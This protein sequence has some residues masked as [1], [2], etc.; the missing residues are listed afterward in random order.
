MV[1]YPYPH[2]I[3]Q[4]YPYSVSRQSAA[5][6]DK[7]GITAGTHICTSKGQVYKNRPHSAL[8]VAP[9]TSTL[10][11]EEPC[12]AM[13]RPTPRTFPF[14]ISRHGYFSSQPIISFARARQRSMRTACCSSQVSIIAR[15]WPRLQLAYSTHGFLQDPYPI[16]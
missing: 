14:P 3:Q 16:L 15:H 1:K 11:I 5:I 4:Y 8:I 6:W 2:R 10:A 9:P 12:I 7:N 13:A